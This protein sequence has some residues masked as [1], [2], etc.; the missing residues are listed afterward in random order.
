M[1]V[2]PFSASI[3][4]FDCENVFLSCRWVLAN[5]MGLEGYV[6]REVC[7]VFYSILTR[8]QQHPVIPKGL[9]LFMHE[10]EVSCFQL[11]ISSVSTGTQRH[12]VVPRPT[13][14]RKTQEL[15]FENFNGKML[16]VVAFL[17]MKR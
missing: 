2:L 7:H 1:V 3:N 6:A 11:E 10:Q 12:P 15:C 17:E 13:R 16:F 5:G 14:K 9:R 8:T 4:T